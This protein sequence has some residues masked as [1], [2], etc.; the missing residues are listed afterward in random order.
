MNSL[1]LSS[2]SSTPS[3]RSLDSTT[4]GLSRT[5]SVCMLSSGRCPARTPLTPTHSRKISLSCFSPCFSTCKQH[6]ALS[7]PT[8]SP[9]CWRARF[10][11][12]CSS[13][14]WC[15]SAIE[16]YSGWIWGWRGQPSWTTQSNSDNSSGQAQSNRLKVCSWWESRTT[17]HFQRVSEEELRLFPCTFLREGTRSMGLKPIASLGWIQWRIPC[18][19]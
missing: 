8:V 13:L 19:W 9:P 6:I 3:S 12:R 10:P 15:G 1:L 18:W 5:F 7:T 14:T 4:S 16:K 11:W 2:S 17:Q